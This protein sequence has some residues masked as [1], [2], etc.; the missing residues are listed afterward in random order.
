MRKLSIN[1]NIE[2]D[3][4]T[5]INYCDSFFQKK[6]N[7][8]TAGFRENFLVP[9]E[10][11]KNIQI[12][13]AGCGIGILTSLVAK[14]QQKNSFIGIDFAKRLV[15]QA[16]KKLKTYANVEF[17]AVDLEYLPFKEG[18]FDVI[19]FSEV[20]EHILKENRKS[21]MQGLLHII[22]SRGNLFLTTP[23]GMY[24]PIF[25]MKIMLY[26]SKGRL[27]SSITTHIYNH[28]LFPQSLTKLLKNAG[29]KVDLFKW[30]E[31]RTPFNK[32]NLPKNL[33]RIP[34]FAIH[35]LVI[36]SPSK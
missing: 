10:R 17:I 18:A 34:L 31:Y 12:L 28:P 24:L 23:N 36:A 9:L 11:C 4:K 6:G 14:S 16:S 8:E 5:D 1:N 13:D 19:I 26:I 35:Q 3:E 33:P 7:Q 2:N 21:V 32:Y 29:W 27:R 15:R 30:A 25:F 22:S 20:L